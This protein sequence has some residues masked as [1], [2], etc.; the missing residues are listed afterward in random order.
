MTEVGLEFEVYTREPFGFQRIAGEAARLQRLGMSLRVIGAALGV[1]EKT[2]RRALRR[3]SQAEPRRNGSAAVI[4]LASRGVPPARGLPTFGADERDGHFSLVLLPRR[5][6]HPI[7]I[8]VARH[9]HRAPAGAHPVR[10]NSRSASAVGDLTKR[11]AHEL[12]SVR[13]VTLAQGIEQ[14]DVNLL[15]LRSRV[16]DRCANHRI[17]GAL[18][19]SPELVRG[20]LFGPDGVFE[21][22]FIERVLYATGVRGAVDPKVN[23]VVVV[24]SAR[25]VFEHIE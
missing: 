24:E 1:D 18:H 13:R 6:L 15:V 20:V 8:S 22:V 19:P 16:D 23:P 10:A 17:A 9:H 25:L 14:G 3:T 21:Q 2:G 12:S 11:S 4:S 5:G 7:R